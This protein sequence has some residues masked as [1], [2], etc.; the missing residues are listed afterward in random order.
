MERAVIANDSQVIFLAGIDE[1]GRIVS[2]PSG[3]LSLNI[4]G[5]DELKK[6]AS[7][8]ESV[9]LMLGI[10]LVIAGLIVGT[11]FRIIARSLRF[12]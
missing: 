6:Q 4:G 10:T 1:G 11:L 12:G 2:P 3:Q 8:Y 7:W 9:I 5:A